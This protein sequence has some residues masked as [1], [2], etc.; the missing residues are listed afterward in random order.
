MQKAREKGEQK[1]ELADVGY[2][3]IL[4]AGIPAWFEISDSLLEN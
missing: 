1:G 2:V 4:T 3:C